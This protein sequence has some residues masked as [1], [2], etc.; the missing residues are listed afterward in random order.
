M[1]KPTIVLL[2]LVIMCLKYVSATASMHEVV[3]NPEEKLC[4]VFWEGDECIRYTLPEG[5]KRFDQSYDRNLIIESKYGVCNFKVNNITYY[6]DDLEKYY[7]SCCEKL[8]FKY[9]NNNSFLYAENTSES[10]QRLGL[11][12]ENI[13]KNVYCSIK[14]REIGF[15][16]NENTKECSRLFDFYLV[17]KYMEYNISDLMPATEEECYLIDSNWGKQDLNSD[18]YNYLPACTYE[19]Q[20]DGNCCIKFGYKFVGF[21]SKYYG[22]EPRIGKSDVCDYRNSKSK[23]WVYV[24]LVIIIIAIIFLIIFKKRNNIK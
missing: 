5:W 12:R 14:N 3:I 21:L 17:L 4:G 19:E 23:F 20:I 1:K 6:R 10:I 13:D 7:Q 22:Q 11:S 24:I 18:Q 15:M 9:V 8:G 2:L 16:F